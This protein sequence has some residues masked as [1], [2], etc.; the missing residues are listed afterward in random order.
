MSYLSWVVAKGQTWADELFIH[1]QFL[2][3]SG[4]K[5]HTWKKGINPRQEQKKHWQDLLQCA[6]CTTCYNF[7]SD[8]SQK[9]TQKEL[10]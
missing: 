10:L 9:I 5:D 2:T 1:S 3:Q 8:I 6:N 7:F 4:I